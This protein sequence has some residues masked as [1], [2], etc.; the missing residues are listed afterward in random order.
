MA[1]PNVTCEFVHHP[2][3]ALTEEAVEVFAGPGVMREDPAALALSGGNI[4]LIEDL[5]RTML[6][7]LLL[8]PGVS[9][10][11]TARDETGAL[12]GFTVFS[13]PGQHMLSTPEQMEIARLNEFMIKMSEVSKEGPAYYEKTMMKEVPELNDKA[14]GI[15]EAERNTYWCNFAMVRADYQGKGVAKAMFELAFNEADK[16]GATVALTTT[17]IRNVPIY[18]TIGLQQCGE[19]ETLQSPWVEWGLWFFKRTPPGSQ[20]T[21]EVTT[22]ERI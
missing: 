2:T 1:P 9:H 20:L 12:I 7:S 6:R 19:P 4:S 3:E 15:Q 16:L 21:T 14:L 10:T 13:L 18:E 11:F 22:Q 5:G 17:N 8:C